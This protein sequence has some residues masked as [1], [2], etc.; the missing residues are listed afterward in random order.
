MN[1][2]GSP[3]SALQRMYLT[4]PCG[5][6]GKGPL[7]TG[8]EPA[9]PTAAKTG[10]LHLVDDLVRVHLGQGLGSCHI[11]VTGDVLVDL[12]R[13]DESPVLQDN[14]LLLAEERDIQHVG[15]G[16]F[17]C[18]LL[19][20][21]PLDRTALDDVLLDDLRNVFGLH[22]LVE[23]AFRI[24]DHDGAC[25]TEAVA[26]GFHHGYLVGEILGRSVPV[27]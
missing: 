11:A 7:H 3:S 1:A 15:N 22:V 20:H 23:G 17:R 12:F 16:R 18:G 21:E 10:F 8:G 25:S 19:V 2:P 13:V 26:A 4:S 27:Q 5:L 9:A 6:A 14:E 24:D